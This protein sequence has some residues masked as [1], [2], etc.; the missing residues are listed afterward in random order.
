MKKCFLFRNRLKLFNFHSSLERWSLTSPFY[1]SDEDTGSGRLTC[2]VSLQPWGLCP[3]NSQSTF[4]RN[5]F[6]PSPLCPMSLLSRAGVGTQPRL[7]QSDVLSQET[8]FGL[9]VTI[10]CRGSEQ[11]SSNYATWAL[12][13]WL[14][15]WSIVLLH[16]K[17]A[18]LILLS[19]RV[20]EATDGCFS[21]SLPAP[22]LPPSLP[23]YLSLPLSLKQ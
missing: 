2:P 4:H 20:Q 19:G 8:E 16:R 12:A 21:L 13:G 1:G 5:L 17:V 14:S 6:G 3:A 23:L 7:S 10:L 11:V 22:S 18:C 15:R 9:I